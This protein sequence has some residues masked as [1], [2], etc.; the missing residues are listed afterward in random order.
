MTNK[1]TPGPWYYEDEAIRAN[2]DTQDGN[3]VANPHWND[4]LPLAQ[5]Q[6]NARLIAAAPELLAALKANMNF[7][8]A[9]IGDFKTVT[10]QAKAAIAKAESK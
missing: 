1:H 5:R 9:G 3:A 10:R 6:A 2:I 7:A 8:L 4:A